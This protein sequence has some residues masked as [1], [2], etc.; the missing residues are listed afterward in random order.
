MTELDAI[1]DY[2]PIKMMSVKPKKSHVKIQKANALAKVFGDSNQTEMPSPVRSAGTLKRLAFQVIKDVYPK[3]V[4]SAIWAQVVWPKELE[5][6]KQ[7]GTFFDG[8]NVDPL[9]EVHWYSQI[10][11]YKGKLLPNLC[12]PQSSTYEYANEGHQRWNYRCT[13]WGISSCLLQ[14]PRNLE[15]CFGEGLAG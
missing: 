12:R 11:K 10:Q 4:L 9:G 7:Q 1:V 6:W 3:S 2:L 15:Q 5:M 13:S 8:I 14:K